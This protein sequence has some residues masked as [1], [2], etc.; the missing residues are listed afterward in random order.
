MVSHEIG[1]FGEIDGLEGQPAEALAAVDG[2]VLGGGGTTTA[3]LRTPFSV[4]SSVRF[5][6]QC[7]DLTAL[8]LHSTDLRRAVSGF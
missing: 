4:H 5:L 6:S 2:F 1:V 8:Y 7:S 3:G